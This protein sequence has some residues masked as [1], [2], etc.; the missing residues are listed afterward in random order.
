[1]KTKS[2]ILTGLL[3]LIMAACFNFDTGD[4]ATLTLYLS[5]SSNSRASL[6]NWPP[7]GDVERDT[8]SYDIKLSGSKGEET[9]KV[10]G[11]ESIT[12]D[13]IPGYWTIE[14]TAYSDNELYA[15]GINGATV[16]PGKNNVLITMNRAGNYEIKINV[17]PLEISIPKGRNY[18]FTASTFYGSLVDSADRIHH[19]YNWS[20]SGQRSSGTTINATGDLTVDLNETANTLKVKAESAN[21]D[22]IY[23][24]ATVT[25]ADL[26]HAQTPVILTGPTYTITGNTIDL[27]VAASAPDGGILSYEW[28]SS[29]TSLSNP[30]SG[31][32]L[33]GTS[34]TIT[35]SSLFIGTKYYYV[36]ITNTNTNVNGNTIATNT[37]A[38]AVTGNFVEVT[39]ITGVALTANVGEALALTGTVN[40][41][42][43]TNKTIVWTVKDAGTTGATIS[44]NT[45]NTT[46]D[47]TVTVIAT[48]TN[49]KIN[50]NYEDYF[51]IEVKSYAAEVIIGG[52]PQNFEDFEDAFNSIGV[53]QIATIKALKNITLPGG[54]CVL[55]GN[56]EVT[57]TCADDY[58]ISLSSNGALFEIGSGATLIVTGNA[59]KT[60]TLKGQTSMNNNSPLVYVNGGDFELKDGAIIEGN[61]T[62]VSGGVYGGGVYV[63]SGSTFTMSGGTIQDN[64]TSGS[65]G[66]TGAGVH[67]SDGGSFDMGGGTI[68]GNKTSSSSVNGGG[69]Y[70]GG[71][72][73]SFDM[74][75]GTI[76]ENTGG[77]GGGVYFYGQAGG[78]FTMGNDAT[79]EDNTATSNGGGVYT[80]GGTFTMYN[81]AAIKGNTA[82]GGSSGGGGV[83]T[84]GGTFGM[85]DN[86]TIEGN[87]V[88]NSA[89]PY[90]GGVYVMNG[91]FTMYGGAIYGTDAILPN[92]PNTATTGASLYVGTTPLT[93]TAKY[94]D[95]TDITTAGVG[96]DTTLTGQP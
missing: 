29:D 21:K 80:N 22:S 73:S 51:P 16:R 69:V 3:A 2:A 76:R 52:T 38:V 50:G 33:V 87:K 48:I 49:G 7:A 60:L 77:N 83:C 88:I 71:S 36:V 45:L 32:T 95:G 66:N 17:L 75:G 6:T 28:Y 46:S 62:S 79:I 65:T 15:Y 72:G 74:S 18:T 55:T 37:G 47:G 30:P 27:T 53:G 8:L 54:A 92:I 42:N 84:N 93:G 78:T 34:D 24:T 68:K 25:V 58:T 20:V 44:G 61:K 59:S 19:S 85:Y 14:V 23:G 13:V 96:I 64:E 89:Y 5:G 10:L 57:L 82:D 31:G 35:Q 40:P 70:V 4:K 12:F 67:V 56:K 9:A 81:D 90:G 1:M 26:V 86:A 63:G 94:G 39:S 91:S 11:S 43:A 41:S